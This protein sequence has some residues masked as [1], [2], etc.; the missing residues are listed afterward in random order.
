MTATRVPPRTHSSATPPAKSSRRALPA[1]YSSAPHQSSNSHT[2]DPTPP[3]KQYSAC[4]APSFVPFQLSVSSNP[5]A[6]PDQLGAQQKY[7]PASSTV[8]RD[9]PLLQSLPLRASSRNE[10]RPAR[11]ASSRSPPRLLPRLSSKVSRAANRAP[12]CAPNLPRLPPRP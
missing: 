2:H 6:L 11:T 9:S 7:P 1:S 3:S 12:H 5:S 8:R 10:R 4:S